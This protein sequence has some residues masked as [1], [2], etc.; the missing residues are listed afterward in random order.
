M[1]ILWLILFLP[2]LSFGQTVH[3]GDDNVKYKGKIT[4]RAADIS[5]QVA[6]LKIKN[7]HLENNSAKPG[8]WQGR[9]RLTTPY[10]L[11][12]QMYFEMRIETSGEG[13]EYVLDNFYLNEEPRKGK[14][15]L[16]P[17]KD[18]LG[19]MEEGGQKA[20]ETERILNETDMK[21][22]ELIAKLKR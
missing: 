17:S 16:V 8:T 13:S 22:Q 18:L 10:Q 2:V 15:K 5:N 3:S 6:A 14:K 1:K 9:I 12:R 21:V 19:A 11:I 4:A 7:V 20:I